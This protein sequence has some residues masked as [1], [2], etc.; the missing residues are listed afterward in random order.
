[1]ASSASFTFGRDLR[2][3][4][5]P[6]PPC[7]TD[8]LMESIENFHDRRRVGLLSDPLRNRRLAGSA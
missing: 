4:D 1:M 6:F 2:R 7:G 5:P 8:A 3:R